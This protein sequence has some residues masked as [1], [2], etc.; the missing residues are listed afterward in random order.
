MSIDYK[1]YVGPYVKVYSPDSPSTKEIET[2]PNPSCSK[3]QKYMGHQK[4]C[5]ECGTKIVTVKLPTMAPLS[6]DVFTETDATMAEL[7]T[8][9]KPK[10]LKDF[11]L[12]VGNRCGPPGLHFNPH[13]DTYA[14]ETNGPAIISQMQQLETMY[15][16][17]IAHLKEVFGKE[18]VQI[19]WGVVGYAR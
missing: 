10:G 13:C 9:T 7:M 15:M 8:E 5:D 1:C 11:R 4:C 14:V 6:F 16:S 3:H 19:K 12:F 18:N 2:C 17:E